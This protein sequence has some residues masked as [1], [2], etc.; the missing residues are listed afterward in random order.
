MRI[1]YLGGIAHVGI[2]DEAIRGAAGAAA[3]ATAARLTGR[4]HP[5]SDGGEGDQGTNKVKWGY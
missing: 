2:D 3:C 1:S 5:D 4:R